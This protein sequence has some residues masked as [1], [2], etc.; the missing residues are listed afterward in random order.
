MSTDTRTPSFA[1]EA[2]RLGGKGAEEVRRMGAVDTADDQ[3][4]ASWPSR[5]AIKRPQAR[6]HR[7]AV[8]DA[9]VPRE[10]WDLAPSPLS[11]GAESGDA[12]LHLRSSVGTARPVR[13]STRLGRSASRFLANSATPGTGVFSLIARTVGPGSRSSSSRGSSP[14]WPHSTP[15]LRVSPP[16]T[17]ASGRSIR[18]RPSAPRSKSSGGCR[19]SR[20]ADGYPP[21]RSPNRAQGPT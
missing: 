16:S 11:S 2:L 7:Q 9:E 4:E 3:V 20:A 18:C 14:R 1:E 19:N 21:S 5:P 12:G 8:W 15:R 17:G 10:L 6:S 13:C